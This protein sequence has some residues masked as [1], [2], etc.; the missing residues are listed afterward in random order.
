MLFE[1]KLWKLIRKN[2]IITIA[3]LYQRFFGTSGNYMSY[4]IFFNISV[5]NCN[6]LEIIPATKNSPCKVK[7][8]L[9]FF[10]KMLDKVPK[11]WYNK[12][13]N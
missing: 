8:K 2:E 1:K 5:L 4:K 9:T 13:R 12:Y 3:E 11:V 6:R 7:R 10:E